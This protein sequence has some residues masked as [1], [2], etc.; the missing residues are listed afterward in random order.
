MYG[1]FRNK[2][3]SKHKSTSTQKSE[4]P[5]PPNTT[6]TTTT[7]ENIHTQIEQVQRLLKRF[8]KYKYAS[9][10]TDCVPWVQ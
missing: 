5:P 6:T 7:Q 4:M 9:I 1:K 2:P 8:N 3:I 10:T